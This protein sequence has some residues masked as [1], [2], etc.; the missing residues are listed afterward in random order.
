[1]SLIRRTV[2]TNSEKIKQMKENPE[3]VICKSCE[4]EA[5]N[6]KTIDGVCEECWTERNKNL[7]RGR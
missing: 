6:Y 4:K 1:M 2:L 7:A 5:W 3:K